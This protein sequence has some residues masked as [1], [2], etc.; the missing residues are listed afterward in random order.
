[1]KKFAFIP[2]LVA[3][4]S[5]Q[6]QPLKHHF[7][8]FYLKGG[9]GGTI[10][11]FESNQNVVLDDE[12]SQTIIEQPVD[13]DMQGTSIAGL[14]GVGYSYQ[15][16]SLW[17]F[18]GEFTIGMTSANGSYDNTQVTSPPNFSSEVK[19]KL[20]NDFAFLFKPGLVVNEK[21][22]FY[23]LI[24]SR[25]GNF[26]TTVSS[27][28]TAPI[29]GTITNSTDKNGYTVGLTVG[30]G[31]ERLITRH[32]GVAFEYAYTAYGNIASTTGNV[33]SE[34]AQG[35]YLTLYDKVTTSAQANNLLAEFIF[36]F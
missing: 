16:D 26:E 34:P 22:Q 21:T 17:V 15:F 31:V 3:T 33:T 9:L 36:R 7:D 24:G 5:L 6:A 28:G 12:L 20:L 18:S 30:I 1:M 13:H 29:F 8:G 35:D 32:W 11:Q 23:G 19:S 14:L 4:T 10:A 27:E 2:L 25:I